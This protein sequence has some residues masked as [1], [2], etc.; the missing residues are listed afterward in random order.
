MV[1]IKGRIRKVGNS[2]GIL[3]PTAL[4][5]NG[6]ISSD[7]EI[8][9]EIKDSKTLQL[10]EEVKLLRSKLENHNQKNSSPPVGI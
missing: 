8:E 2:Y 9:V 3:I 10:E 4:V 1:I 5:R 6:I 7:G